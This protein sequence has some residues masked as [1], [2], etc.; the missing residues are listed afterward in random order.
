MTALKTRV[1]LACKDIVFVLL[2]PFL[3]HT[4]AYQRWK[5]FDAE[6]RLGQ[7]AATK[8]AEIDLLGRRLQVATSDL[9]VLSEEGALRENQFNRRLERLLA[10]QIESTTRIDGLEAALERSSGEIL[11]LQSELDDARTSLSA[12]TDAATGTNEND[13]PTLLPDEQFDADFYLDLYPDVKAAGLDPLWHYVTNG[14]REGRLGSRPVTALLPGWVAHDPSKEYVM[15]VSHEASRTGAPILSLNLVQ[16][17]RAKYNIVSLLLGEG[18]LV[19]AFRRESVMVA[20]PTVS[21]DAA[22]ASAAIAQLTVAFKFKFALVNSIEASRVLEP[23]ARQH[24]PSVSLIHEFA[25]YTRPRG[26]FTKALFWSSEVIFSTELTY[27]DALIECPDLPRRVFPQGRST[28]DEPL[29]KGLLERETLRV[30]TTLHPPGSPGD[31]I[32]VVGA[33]FVHI[34]KGVDLFIACASRVRA[35]HA[36]GRCRFVWV[37]KGYDPESDLG[38]SIYLQQQIQRA[39][40]EDC[41]TFMDETPC[42]E[43]VYRNADVFLISSRLDPL[44]N[45]GIDAMAHGLPLICFHGATG[46][47]EI[48]TSGGMAEQ[49]VADHLDTS[50]MADRVIAFA[51]S[52][53]LRMR[54]GH[55]LKRLA[56]QVFDMQRYVESIEQLALSASKRLETERLDAQEILKSGLVAHDFFGASE[57]DLIDDEAAIRWR[58]LRAWGTGIGRRKPFPGFH[59]GIYDDA[60]GVQ[61]IAGDPFAAYLRSGRPAGP[62]H[63]DLVTPTDVVPGVPKDLRVALHIHVYY[64]DLLPEILQRLDSNIAL[65][66]LFV[67][68]CEDAATEVARLL[69]SYRGKVA[70]VVVVPNRGRDIGPFL[71]GFGSTFVEDYDI[72]G[73]V[74]TKKTTD[75]DGGMGEHW[76]YFLYEN[77]IGGGVPM[78]DIIL[79]RMAEDNHIGL[80]FPDDPHVV[81]WGKNKGFADAYSLRLGL[82]PLPAHWVFP[83]GT[84]FWARTDAL[85]PIFSLGLTWHDYPSEPLPY[86]GSELHAIER[87]LPLVASSAGYR[88]VLTNVPGISR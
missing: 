64:Q 72:V 68:V 14:R 58:Y 33:G 32:V 28:L 13:G 52:P 3:R 81:G 54:T 75:I 59:P 30:E 12:A 25:C 88:S 61:R 16:Q 55:K 34:R 40:L 15:V 41:V 42:I 22:N 83:V 57:G 53:E 43:A 87:L 84:M 35:S 49:C 70:A 60:E 46:I 9:A 24:V 37:G 23:L 86:D 36:G 21:T 63:Q 26:L 8:E 56:A 66:N 85:R 29:D 10:E 39:G 74:H 6:H 47:A 45:V 44:P 67:S 17:L 51:S 19:E 20:G 77:L 71:S 80:V 73:H 76:R 50:G 82:G 11:A 31:L 1:R 62:W 69:S 18:P 2:S 65:P 27:Q 7:L 78:A 48:L 79:G 4:A 5:D 38:Y